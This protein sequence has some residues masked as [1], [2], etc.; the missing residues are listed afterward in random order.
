MILTPAP[1]R[2][3]GAFSTAWGTHWVVALVKRWRWAVRDAHITTL[4]PDLWRLLAIIAVRDDIISLRDI[5]GNL[6]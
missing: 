5:N 1:T 2:V 6:N 3:A 4:L